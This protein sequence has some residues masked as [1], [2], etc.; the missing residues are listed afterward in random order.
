VSTALI[1]DVDQ[2]GRDMTPLDIQ[3]TGMIILIESRQGDDEERVK[4]LVRRSSRNHA[5]ISQTNLPAA[6]E[7]T[8]PVANAL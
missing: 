3:A 2:M 4:R 1:Y 8:S 5:R 7:G 6:F